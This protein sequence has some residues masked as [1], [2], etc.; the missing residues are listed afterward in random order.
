[1]SGLSL[2]RVMLRFLGLHDAIYQKTGGW[3]GHR[4]PG[5]PPNLLL[6]TVGARTGR[7]RTTSLTYASDGD[8]YLIVASN[9]GANR[10]P[11]WYHNLR[12]RPDCGINVGPKRIAVTAREVGPDDADYARLWEIVNANNA[13]RYHGYQRRTT[14]PIP[15]F[16]LTS[17]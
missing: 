15:I 1:M 3:I 6:H 14:R 17:R 7:P 8:S 13:D 16:V 4:V 9:A 10:Y 2:D 5:M 11:G 12:K